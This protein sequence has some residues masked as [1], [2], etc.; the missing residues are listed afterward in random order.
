MLKFE[1]NH[2]LFWDNPVE[3]VIDKDSYVR[4]DG[5][6]QFENYEGLVK[7]RRQKDCLSKD[8]LNDLLKYYKKTS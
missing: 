8:K 7:Y 3:K 1:K 5:I 2:V 4:L 6:I